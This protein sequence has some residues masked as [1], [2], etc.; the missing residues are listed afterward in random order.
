ME[1]PLTPRERPP[2]GATPAQIFEAKVA[3]REEVAGAHALRAD[4][5]PALRGPADGAVGRVRRA[6]AQEAAD[7]GSRAALLK[8]RRPPGGQRGGAAVVRYRH[9]ERRTEPAATAPPPHHNAPAPSAAPYRN[10]S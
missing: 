2:H 1:R 7:R 10:N 9:P 4:K 3:Y 6:A 8:K 5:G